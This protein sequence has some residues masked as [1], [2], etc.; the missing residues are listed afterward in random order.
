MWPAHALLCLGALAQLEAI[1]VPDLPLVLD[2]VELEQAASVA[3]GAPDPVAFEAAIEDLGAL[4]GA[5]R[6]R[7]GALT[8][9]VG[10]R[11]GAREREVVERDR[12]S[13][14]L[15]VGIDLEAWL[16][17]PD[18]SL[19]L[20]RPPE[21]RLRA[22]RC[23]A[24]VRGGEAVA[25]LDA[26]PERR[27]PRRGAEPEA[28]GARSGVSKAPAAVG[29]FEVH[30]ERRARLERARALGCFVAVAATEGERAP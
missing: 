11:F 16:A 4:H 18:P 7:R 26:A 2:A 15:R 25:A 22:E 10:L 20:R 21:E 3:E 28:E 9:E 27:R 17:G 5:L 6:A 13:A 24:L 29:D 19:V 8:L 14:W 30:L 1:D 23:A 12:I